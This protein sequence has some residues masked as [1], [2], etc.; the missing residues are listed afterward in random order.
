MAAEATAPAV[1]MVERTLAQALEAGASDLHLESTNAG[2]SIRVRI[3][4]HLHALP[5]PPL[6]LVA[7]MLTRI[8]L[9]AG[10]DLAAKHLPQDGAFSATTIGGRTCEVRAS[11]LPA[12]GG[13]KIV[14]RL[15][16]KDHA[17]LALERLGMSAPQLGVLSAA[18]GAANGLVLATGPT[19]AGKST[20]L[21][22]SLAHLTRPERSVVTVEDP[23]ESDVPG[24][25]RISVDDD[26]GRDFATILRALLRQDPDVI[27]VGEMRDTESARIA[28]RAALTGHLVLSTLHTSDARQAVTRL[29]DMGVPSHLVAATVSL[30]IAQRLL[31]RLCEQCK[32]RREPSGAERKLFTACG[33]RPPERLARSGGCS[34]CGGRGSAGRLAV[35]E[36]WS[37]ATPSAAASPTLI[38]SGLAAAARLDADIAD[39]VSVCPLPESSA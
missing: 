27:L 7:P 1:R 6:S 32:S 15:L 17:P 5:S 14:L 26:V 36:L 23:V 30:V 21:F 38:A 10:A 16:R 24:V 31:R 35:F 37:P 2:L 3:D 28:C 33:L 34:A 19:G 12:V 11:F 13:E 29:I 9:M 25:T 18:L 4:G 20:T 39:V 22:A 8:R